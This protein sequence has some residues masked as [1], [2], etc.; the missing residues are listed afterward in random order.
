MYLFILDVFTL[1]VAHLRIIITATVTGF[2]PW[3]ITGLPSNTH[4]ALA[5]AIVKQWTQLSLL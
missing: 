1:A 2:H 4:I 5:F 3:L